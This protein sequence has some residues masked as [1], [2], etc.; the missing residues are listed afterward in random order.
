MSTARREDISRRTVGVD[1]DAG[2]LHAEQDGD[3]GEVDGVVDVE[4]GVGF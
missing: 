3:E 2:L 4:E 1:A